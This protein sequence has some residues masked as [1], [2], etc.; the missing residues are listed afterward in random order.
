MT[1][2]DEEMTLPLE[3]PLD[4]HTGPASRLPRDRA[5]AM[6]GAALHDF[7]PTTHARNDQINAAS[8]HAG[9]THAASGWLSWAAAA[10]TLLAVVGSVAAARFYFHF[11]AAEGGAPATTTQA[12]QRPSPA[13]IAAPA[14]PEVVEAGETVSPEPAKADKPARPAL[15]V[16][17]E[18]LLQRANQQRTA[19]Q[20]K[21][22]A[23]S[24]AL[25]YERYPRSLSAYVAR[26]AGAALELEHLQNPKHA[27]T[28]FEQA[29]RERP[30]G[31][32]D[33]EARQ[34]LLLALR[35]L[36]DHTAEQHA[37]EALISA[38]AG[39]PAARRAQ[40]RL[41]ELSAAR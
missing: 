25:V 1:E 35:D 18:D 8:K 6:V 37:L 22:A 17:S 27:R 20:F 14:Q 19:G 26:V 39:S 41:R 40:Q 34:G 30:N 16:T 4:G 5:A 32:L 31:A 9:H 21:D 33:L 38:H 29:L 24:Y 36:G 2:V 28:L 23:Q 3:L 13:A 7:G 10:G 12:A 15:R 11:G